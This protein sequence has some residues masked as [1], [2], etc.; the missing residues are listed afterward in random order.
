MSNNLKKN[1]RSEEFHLDVTEE[2]YR[3]GRAKGISE[4]AL[5]KPGRHTFR[6]RSPERAAK[7]ADSGSRKVKVRVNIHLDLDVINY[8]KERAALPNAAPYQTQ[9][10]QALREVME[11]EQGA[12]SA[13]S[14]LE[15]FEDA[16]FV[17]L[18]NEHIAAQVQNA[19]R[20]AKR[21]R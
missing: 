4:D 3:A 8:F 9:I 18:L 7:F 10:N 5:L 12:P 13:S 1:K 6:R 2:D 19:K 14:L 11:H 20:P 16:R 17:A 21:S 15:A